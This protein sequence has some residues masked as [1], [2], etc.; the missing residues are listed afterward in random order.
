MN[1]L[2]IQLASPVRV[3]LQ[4]LIFVSKLAKAGEGGKLVLARRRREV[5]AEAPGK[6]RRTRMVAPVETR[7]RRKKAPR[8][9]P[10]GVGGWGLG[11]V[12]PG[13]FGAGR[14]L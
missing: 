3:A 7:R 8:P 13:W 2:G 9:K 4:N 11:A 12:F 5:A 1:T 10:A 6:V 14:D